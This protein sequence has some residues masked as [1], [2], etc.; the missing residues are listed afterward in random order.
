M[1]VG[2]AEIRQWHTDPPP[3]GRGWAAIGYHYVIRRN[4]DVEPGRHVS[5]V[6][7]H[8]QGHNIESV[9]ICL[10]GGVNA[11]NQPEANFTDA[12]YAAL[13]ELLTDLSKQYPKAVIRGHR[14]FP[15]VQ[16]ACP[17]FAAIDWARARGLRV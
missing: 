8:V 7:T 12:Q 9:G 4:G 16:K 11:Q 3:Q 14:D 1:D 2:V 10:V 13:A 17:S 15:K 5:E 6:G